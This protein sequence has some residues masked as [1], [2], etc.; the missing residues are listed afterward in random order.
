MELLVTLSIRYSRTLPVGYGQSKGPVK[1]QQQLA[2]EGIPGSSLGTIVIWCHM[3]R[4]V[5]CAGHASLGVWRCP[6]SRGF[7]CIVD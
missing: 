4:S 1:A 3:I 2:A 5:C 6:S 7:C